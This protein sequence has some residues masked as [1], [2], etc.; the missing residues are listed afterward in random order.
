MTEQ[1]KLRA[2]LLEGRP[3]YYHKNKNT[4]VP[5]YEI[6]MKV[7]GVWEDGVLYVNENDPD[8]VFARLKTDFEQSMTAIE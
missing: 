8:K 6:R 7:N 2:A 3:R 4:Y 1:Q 5:I